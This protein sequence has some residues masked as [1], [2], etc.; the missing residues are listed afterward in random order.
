M[1]QN[2]LKDFL[3]KIIP[4]Q[5][6]LNYLGGKEG[7]IFMLNGE[8]FFQI[9]FFVQSLLSIVQMMTAGHFIMGWP[10]QRAVF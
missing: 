5:E 10:N 7:D 4:H 2:T 3:L 8:E 6:P 9:Y 1:F